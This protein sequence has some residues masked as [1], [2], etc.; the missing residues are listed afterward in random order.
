MAKT[1]NVKKNIR[2]AKNFD[3]GDFAGRA[4]RRNG[5]FDINSFENRSAVSKISILGILSGERSAETVFLT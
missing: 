2:S 4:I 1:I 5:F 3:L